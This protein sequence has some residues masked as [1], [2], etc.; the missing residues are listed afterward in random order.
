[1]QTVRVTYTNDP[2]T[3]AVYTI[4]TMTNYEGIITTERISALFASLI[5][6]PLII[7]SW[8]VLV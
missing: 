3:E 2:A 7:V 8:E 5:T 1:M 4:T 6:E